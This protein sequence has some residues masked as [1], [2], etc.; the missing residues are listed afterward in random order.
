MVARDYP[1]YLSCDTVSDKSKFYSV[2]TWAQC[3]KTFSTV[4]INFLYLAGFFIHGKVFKPS[5]MF[6]G[7][8]GAYPSE[9]PSSC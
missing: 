9:A 7:K 8:A 6:T 5:L 4:I 1:K 3:Y 2:D